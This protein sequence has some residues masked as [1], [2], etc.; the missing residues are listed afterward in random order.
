MESIECIGNKRKCLEAQNGDTSIE[1][2]SMKKYFMATLTE[3]GK[4]APDMICELGK[5]FYDL[6]WVSGTG[7]GIS[8]KN[9]LVVYKKILFN[10]FILNMKLSALNQ[11]NSISY[12]LEN[13]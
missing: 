12:D 1:N 2:S 13:G 6:G 3:D 4:S 9:G 11:L 10:Y 7:G 5:S 8:I